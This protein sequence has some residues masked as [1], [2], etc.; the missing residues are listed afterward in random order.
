MADLLFG[1]GLAADPPLWVFAWGQRATDQVARPPRR[2]LSV[3]PGSRAA[4]RG[5]R[6]PG[7]SG[8]GPRPL[9]GVRSHWGTPALAP[10]QLGH[11]SGAYPPGVSVV[12]PQSAN[13]FHSLDLQGFC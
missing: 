12:G 5:A 3:C 13:A 4:Y 6:P 10:R 7:V 1:L 2:F 8:V 9:I 11:L